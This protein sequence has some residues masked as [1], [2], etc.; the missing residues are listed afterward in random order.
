MDIDI[1]FLLTII[2][3]LQ[4]VIAILLFL[5]LLL[6]KKNNKKI[7]DGSL[8]YPELAGMYSSFS[9]DSDSRNKSI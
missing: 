1:R 3:V 8:V 5:I 2:I 9:I 4:I 6:T 7:L